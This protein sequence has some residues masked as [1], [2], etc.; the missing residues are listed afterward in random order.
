MKDNFSNN[1]SEYATY[2]P[3]Y[4]TEL[5]QFLNS[6]AQE[7]HTAWD[8]AT[9]NGQV[10]IAL[11]RYFDSVDATDLSAKQ[12]SNATLHEKIN[13]RTEIAETT[14]FDDFRF[15]LITVAQAIHWFDF[16]KF[17]MEVDRVL[18]PG[19]VLAVFGYALPLVDEKFNKVFLHFYNVIVGPYWDAERHYVDEHYQTIPL[20]YSE[21]TCPRF[22]SVYQW[23]F[24]QFIGFLSTWSGVAHYKSQTGNDPLALYKNELKSG[25]GN[26]AVKTITFEVFCRIGRKSS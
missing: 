10:A 8:C 12:I 2:R 4:P 11:T 19:G 20:P 16:E 1:S 26:D 3:S 14:S 18:K 22:S 15:D 21:I 17:Y 7:H 5:F 9:G 6:L 24:D 25:W 13:Y 23:T